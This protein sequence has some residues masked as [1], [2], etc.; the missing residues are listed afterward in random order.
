M[1]A[2]LEQGWQIMLSNNIKQFLKDQ[3]YQAQGK[4]YLDRKGQAVAES[5]VRG[6][7]SKYLPSKAQRAADLAYQLY[8]GKI[9]EDEAVLQALESASPEMAFDLRRQRFMAKPNRLFGGMTPAEARKLLISAVPRARANLFLLEI[10]K[11]YPPG[12][13]FED[14]NLLATSVEYEPFGLAGD[15][16]GVGSAVF[17]LPTGSE[18][19]E[20]AITTQDDEKG[21]LKRWFAERCAEVMRPDGTFG[22]PYEYALEISV[23][24]AFAIKHDAAYLD[25]G[26]FRPVRNGFSLNRSESAMQEIQLTF[27]QLDTFMS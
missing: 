14:F 6:A 8:E 20:L 10:R 16:T 1:V 15:K 4:S 23:T 19:V 24:H 22:V 11:K 12:D 26:L 13:G 3:D 18:A 17:D 2:A 7:L 27:T 9:T 5:K 21:T 25:K